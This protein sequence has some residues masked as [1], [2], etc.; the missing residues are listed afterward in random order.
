MLKSNII[1][2]LP[3]KSKKGKKAILF[4]PP[5]EGMRYIVK[6]DDYK[7][8]L[9]PEGEMLDAKIRDISMQS[10]MFPLDKYWTQQSENSMS[11]AFDI[12]SVRTKNIISLGNFFYN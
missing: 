1:F 7:T 11:E 10:D 5:P 6:W 9:A 12:L 8:P 3:E 2:F 4:K